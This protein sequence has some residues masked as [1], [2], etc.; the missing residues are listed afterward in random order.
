[1]ASRP[2]RSK[3][4]DEI[5]NEFDVGEVPGAPSDIITF[6]Y[7]EYTKD[8][9]EIDFAPFIKR[10]E[11]RAAFHHN[12]LMGAETT[13]ANSLCIIRREWWSIPDAGLVVVVIYFKVM[14]LPNAQ[15]A[16]DCSSHA[17]KRIQRRAGQMGSRI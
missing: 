11:N 9:D 16:L 13:P 4:P 3:A 10:T 5:Y 7:G 1:M 14:I 15:K 6:S 17:A 2:V 12:L 8:G